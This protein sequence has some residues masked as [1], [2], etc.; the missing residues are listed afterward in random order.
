VK[1]STEKPKIHYQPVDS[2]TSPRFAGVRTFMRLPYVTTTEGVDVA[3]AG[4]PF[5]TGASFKVGARFGPEAI[6][7]ASVLLRPYHPE[8]D[9]EIFKW[10]SAVDYGD[11]P[12]APGFIED[13][14]ERIVSFLQPL[15]AAGVI[16]I[17]LGGDHSIALAEL[18]AAARQYGPLALVLFDSHTDTWE[19]YFGHRYFHGTP[20]KRAVEE[21]LLVPEHST[22]IGIRGPLYDRNDLK[23]TRAMGF[24]IITAEEMHRSGIFELPQQILA[25]ASNQPVFLSFDI[26]FLDPAY[27]P[28]T[29]TPEVGG[30]ATWQAQYLL[31]GL[32]GLKIVAADVVEVLPA[33]D[34]GQITAHA[35]ATIAWE[36]LSLIAWRR[37][38][39][40]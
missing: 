27:A 11:A 1:N 2:M 24:Q 21:E 4:L 17:A 13:S 26:D 28:G 23:N 25:R 7:S 12:V 18:R 34:H 33:N 8:L 36:I 15:H 35:A 38:Q 40:L 3:F 5:D 9:I 39:S 20:F 32:A 29:G 22:M 31:R 37:K 19:S 6:R 16:P 30:F 10:L 14:Y